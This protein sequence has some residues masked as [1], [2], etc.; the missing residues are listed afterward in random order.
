[1]KSQLIQ[2]VKFLLPEGFK[3]YYRKLKRKV[4]RSPGDKISLKELREIIVRELGIEAGDTI[5]VHSSFGSLFGDFSPR[6]VVD[7]LM[8]II[9]PSGN[10]LMPYYPSGQAYHWIQTNQEFDVYQSKSCMGILTETFKA[11]N[12]VRLS[13]HP[14]K[15]MAVWGKDRDY[16]IED[17]YKSVYPY[18]K[19]SP[20][21]RTVLLPNSKTIGLGVEINS[22]IHVCED[23]FLTDKSDLYAEKIFKGKV[24]YYDRHFEI[25]TY[26][27]EPKKVK[28]LMTGCSYLKATNFAPYNYY[29]KNGTVFFSTPNKEVLRHSKPLFSK[30][31]S[32][33][34]HSIPN[35]QQDISKFGA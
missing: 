22:F 7:L 14:V 3:R 10:I 11:F 17:H 16:L 28:G 15:S 31:I 21:Y 20:Y 13:P 26:L 12:E 23:M 27:H 8:E 30:G 24:K 1:M 33:N 5:I 9:T 35:S 2:Y 32:R 4:G 25:N 18:D 6:Q 34:P 29:S 19:N